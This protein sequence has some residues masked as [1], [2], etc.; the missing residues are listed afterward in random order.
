MEQVQT[1]PNKLVK[2]CKELNACGD[3]TAKLWKLIEFGNRMQHVLP[4]EERFRHWKVSGCSSVVYIRVSV[5]NDNV[6]LL[7]F[8][9][10][11]VAK[12]LLALLVLG[13]DSASTTTVEQLSA[14]TITKLAGLDNSLSSSRIGGLYQI[15]KTIQDKCKQVVKEGDVTLFPIDMD[16]AKD[17][18]AVLL[19]G[20]V[21][22]SVAMSLLI[23]QGYR[24]K[25]FYLRIWLEDELAHLG[26]CP[27]EEDIAYANAVC[28]QFGLTLE[29]INLQKEYWDQV[30]E[31]TL[32]EVLAGRTPNPDIMCNNRIKFGVF[33]DQ[34]SQFHVKL[35]LVSHYARIRRDPK[36][37]MM[38]LLTSADPWKDQT[39]FLA[40]L[41]QEQLSKVIFPIGHLTKEMVRKKAHELNL[42]TKDRKD[43]QGIC[44]LG[45]IKFDE[46]LRYHLGCRVG[47][48][49]EFETGR[50][51]GEHAGYWFYTAGQRKGLYL[52]NGPWYV[53]TKDI[54]SNTVF[55]SR[56]YHTPEK[57][58]NQFLVGNIRWHHPSFLRENEILPVQVKIRHGKEFH[59]GFLVREEQ[60]DTL[61]V[62]LESR[63]AGIAPGQ[64]AVFYKDCFECLGAGVITKELSTSSISS[65]RVPY[66]MS[67]LHTDIE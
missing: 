10:S 40:H 44:F 36:S 56:N 42:A 25:P 67:S 60:S 66:R 48:L 62:W 3:K 52:S 29:Q 9:D 55:V 11:K 32:E 59:Q 57:Q 18:I 21:D 19:S 65:E 27:W 28:K 41:A 1:I 23:E 17:D 26:K 43:S 54:E 16:E 39:Y 35:L 6:S 12:G 5:Q 31:Y 53:V 37:D 8:A 2:L 13:L 50:V 33:L 15:L 58:R 22:S 47:N 38:Q 61:K 51:V 20:G 14:D 4:E 45:K 49:V 34:V 7:G 64:F 30:V 24:V 46:F 63:D